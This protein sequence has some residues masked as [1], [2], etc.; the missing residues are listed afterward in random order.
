AAKGLVLVLGLA[1]LGALFHS[2]RLKSLRSPPSWVWPLGLLL[3]WGGLSA[4]WAIDPAHSLLAA[5]RL[6]TLLASAVILSVFAQSLNDTERQKLLT[7]AAGSGL[8]FLGVFVLD[9]VSGLALLRYVKG[10]SNASGGNDYLVYQN[11]ATLS[12]VLL[13][14]PLGLAVLQR[15]GQRWGMAYLIALP[16]LTIVFAHAQ[17]PGLAALISAIAGFWLAKWIRPRQAGFAVAAFVLAVPFVIAALL[18]LENTWKMAAEFLLGHYVD[19]HLIPH[20]LL[21]RI[22]IWNFALEKLWEQPWLG[23]GLDGSRVIPGGR[24]DI[25]NFTHVEVMPLHPH[26]GILQV[27]LELGVVGAALT[28]LAGYRIA[29][30]LFEQGSLLDRRIALMTFLTYLIL[31]T[32]S[33]GAW[34]NWWLA[35][36]V[37]SY[38]IFCLSKT[39]TECA[40]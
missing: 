37:L 28:A 17:T 7:Y 18:S 21:H 24:A 12:L 10:L 11:P 38:F 2:S 4:L 3:I 27:W 26:N 31:L 39:K 40:S 5:G 34:Q 35:V 13:G 6:L 32:F 25:P 29:S 20:S 1:V 23:W 14:F 16:A 30:R 8:V 36:V 15:F 9:A 22:G 19:A 33:L